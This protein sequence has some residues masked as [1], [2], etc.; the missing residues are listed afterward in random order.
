MRICYCWASSTGTRTAQGAQTRQPL[1]PWRNVQTVVMLSSFGFWVVT[2]RLAFPQQPT[3]SHHWKVHRICPFLPWVSKDSFESAWKPLAS[4]DERREKKDFIYLLI[5]LR[6]EPLNRA[7][8]AGACRAGACGIWK[9]WVPSAAFS[10][11]MPWSDL[12]YL[13]YGKTMHW[14][15]LPVPITFWRDT[16]RTWAGKLYKT[17]QKPYNCE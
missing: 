9:W 10:I 7:G 8:Q 14:A 15:Q 13:D 6:L 4:W 3:H 1:T 5:Y 16:G 11:S 17:V 12:K 2:Q